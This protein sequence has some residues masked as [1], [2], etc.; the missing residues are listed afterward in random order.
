MIYSVKIEGNWFTGYWVVTYANGKVGAC[1]GP[2]RWKEARAN[3]ALQCSA[4]GIEGIA[5]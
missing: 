2:F 3:A 5:A 4:Y 1:M